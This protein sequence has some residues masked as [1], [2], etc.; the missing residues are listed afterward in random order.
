MSE[1]VLVPT[2]AKVM[3]APIDCVMAVTVE[4]LNAA[5]ERLNAEA[6]ATGA[7]PKKL[8]QFRL[9]DELRKTMPRVTFEEIT[10]RAHRA[11]AVEDDEPL[12]EGRTIKKVG[13]DGVE[14][15]ELLRSFQHP[16]GEAGYSPG[17]E[18]EMRLGRIPKA[19]QVAEF[20][21]GDVV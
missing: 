9:A 4:Q 6:E 20:K 11:P 12:V 7:D 16:G 14:R 10:E 2:D 5:L 19:M 1:I 18:T 3:R 15:V 13:A 21:K 8:A 17:G